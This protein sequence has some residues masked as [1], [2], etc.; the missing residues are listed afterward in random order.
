MATRSAP[1]AYTGDDKDYIGKARWYAERIVLGEIDACRPVKR[2]CARHLADLK[3]VREPDYP[4]EFN[5]KLGA[6]ICKFAELLPH[7]KGKWARDQQLIH[8]QPWQCF[9]LTCIFGWVHKS[10]GLRRFRKT[11]IEVPRKNGKSVL[12]AVVA[13]Y[14]FCMDGE[15]GAEVYSGATSEK[16]AWEVFRPA[17]QMF[18]HALALDLRA[19]V[20]GEV[21]AKSLNTADGSRFE[22]IIGKPGDGSSP[23]CAVADEFHEHET[24]DQVDTMETGMG[25]REQPLMLVVT[26]A[27]VNLAGP[28]YDMRQDAV[29]VLEGT[30]D[31]DEL[32][33]IVYSIDLPEVEGEKGDDWADPKALYKANPNIGISVFEDFLLAQQRQAVLNPIHQTRFKTKH[34]NIWCSAKIQWMPMQAWK[35]CG[36]P[37]LRLDDFAGEESYFILDLASKDDIAAFMQW[38]FKDVKEGDKIQRHHYLFAEY[39]IPE[40]QLDNPDNPNAGLYRKWHT[41]GYLTVTPGQEIDFDTIG[42]DIK[43]YASKLQCKELLYDPWRATQLVQQAKKDGL[44]E[45]VELRQTVQI[46]SLPMKELLSAVKAHRV[47]HDHNPITTWM[48]S[49]VT[50]LTDRKDNIYPNKEKPQYKIDGAVTA[51]MG[52]SRAMLGTDEGSIE[53]ALRNPVVSRPGGSATVVKQRS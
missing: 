36:D 23:H 26:T 15:H 16:Q 19:K 8:L 14:M 10:S 41:Q 49:N 24:S 51:I 7:V 37:E 44:V 4:Y 45:A 18:E 46:L 39:Y 12:A 50:A 1:V 5:E 38:I 35:L 3:R 2:A 53:D 6:R 25:A 28:C 52:M 47:H 43:W 31:Y 27:G 34:L 9:I 42:D 17:K 13:L 48:V 20:G 40:A 29:K 30:L 22:P 32:F 33:A 21:W 11:Y